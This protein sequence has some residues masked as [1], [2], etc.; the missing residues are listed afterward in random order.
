MPVE[1]CFPDIA[2]SRR[3]ARWV[4]TTIAALPTAWAAWRFLTTGRAD[5]TMIV[6][7]TP[8]AAFALWATLRMQR[9]AAVIDVDVELRTYSVV[10]NGKPCGS[11]S[12]DELGPLSMHLRRRKTE[13]GTTIEYVVVPAKHGDISLWEVQSAEEAREKMEALAR[14]WRLP[15]QSLGGAVRA[16][17]A[18]DQPLHPRLRGDRAATVAAPLQPEWG[19]RIEPIFRGQAIVSTHRSWTPMIEAGILALGTLVLLAVGGYKGVLSVYRGAIEDPLDRVLLALM[20]AAALSLAWR[21]LRGALDTL[22][23]GAVRVT[24]RGVS[25]R[26]T[27]IAFSDIEEVTSAPGV[28]VVGDRRKLALPASFCPREADHALAHE[29]QRLILEIAPRH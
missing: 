29:I 7:V 25:Y 14:A 11:G 13:D 10:R 15:S 16:A 4:F 23:P 19:L 18:V 5:I 6:F 17:D 8:P 27:R 12:L 26:W 9:D 21:L 2:R 24:E 3:T 1:R 22:V 20:A 28:E